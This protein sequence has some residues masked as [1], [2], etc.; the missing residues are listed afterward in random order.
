MEMCSETCGVVKLQIMYKINSEK[1]ALEY[2]NLLHKTENLLIENTSLKKHLNEIENKA[3]NS[4]TTYKNTITNLLINENLDRNKI[5][6]NVDECNDLYIA[7]MNVTDKVIKE[8]N[9]FRDDLQRV[10]EENMC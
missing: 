1:S 9:I 2:A 6:E 7:S 10:K 8:R 5:E 4:K 3:L